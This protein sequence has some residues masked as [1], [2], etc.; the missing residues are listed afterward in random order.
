KSA[1]N[2]I[3]SELDGIYNEEKYAKSQAYMSE[4]S[5]FSTLSTSISFFIT[6]LAIFFGWFG[7]LDGFLRSYSPFDMITPLMFFGV[8]YLASD[9][10]GIPFS[11]Y[12]NFVIEEKYGFNKMTKKTFWFDKL[13]GLLLT[14]IIGGLLLGVF[15]YM[16]ASLG[17]EFWVYF[18]AVMVAFTLFANLFYTSLILPL[19][20]KLKPIE[21]GDLK[22]SIQGYCEKVKFPLKNIF[23]IDGSK[24]SSKGNAFFSGLGKRK[25]V[26]LYDTLIENHSVD[27]LTA[28]FAH[29]VGHFKKKH[30]LYSTFISI[31]IM[32]LMLYMLS[33]MILNFQVSW[34]MGGDITAIHLN[35]LAFGI[36]YSPVS[37][38]IGLLG[39]MLSRKNEYEADAFAKETFKAEHLIGA[40][41]KMS[42]DHLSNLTPHP[43]Y[44]FVH[45]SHPTL[46]QRVRAMSN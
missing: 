23:I 18:W 9:I 19:F 2:P 7:W 5:G 35:I 6:F 22:S 32:G 31:F 39:N 33:L 30:I 20:N 17:S 44:V 42:G 40:L 8:L 43:A 1:E 34:A 46:L 21:D 28:V 26:V 4:L 41:K 29:E 45:Y 10:I 24:R 15:I 36:L 25:K 16:V 11:L 27:E 13:K 14:V 12:R 37:R 3:P 38:I